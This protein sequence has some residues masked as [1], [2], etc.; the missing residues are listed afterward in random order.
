VSY[1]S[2]GRESRIGITQRRYDLGEGVVLGG[3]VGNRIDSFEFHSDGEVIA[4]WAAM[5]AG[6]AR[7]PCSIGELDELRQAAIAGHDQVRGHPKFT[8]FRKI[9]VHIKRQRVAKKPIYPGTAKFTGW[10]AY[11][12]HDDEFRLHPVWTR[13]EIRRSH[14]P[15]ALHESAFKIYLQVKAPI[16]A[17][18]LDSICDNRSHM[19]ATL[20]R[21]RP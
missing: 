7:M 14:L 21:V 3:L 18:T 1:Q 8:N 17:D 2:I 11:A 20:R 15:G 5:I 10:Q 4:G 6:L 13:I 16:V 19:N 12:V 9:G